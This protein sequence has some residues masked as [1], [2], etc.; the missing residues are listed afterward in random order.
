VTPEVDRI[1]NKALAK[2]PAE[3]YQHADD[4]LPDLRVLQKQ[5]GAR[6]TSVVLPPAGTSVV[7]PADTQ[8]TA[9]EPGQGSR[10]ILER[11]VA[12]IATLAFLGLLALHMSEPSGEAPASLTRRF[13]ISQEGLSSA[14]VSPDGRYV[15]FATGTMPQSSLWLR[16]IGAETA[17]EIPGTEGARPQV[18]WSPDSQSIVFA[19]RAEI[20][21][22]G[23]DGADP[24]TLGAL[25]GTGGDGLRG[26]SWSPDGERIVFSSARR[27]SQIPA[28]G[29]EARLLLD[30]DSGDAV[31]PHFLPMTNGVDVIVYQTNLDAD[32]QIWTLNLET[33]ERSEVGPGSAPVYSPDGYLIHGPSE[34]DE[35][36]LHALPFSLA[37]LQRTGSSFPIAAGGR[38][39]SLA[40]DGTLV[41]WDGSFAPVQ[42]ALVWRDRAGEVIETI[43]RP[44]ARMTSPS[45]S[46]DGQRIAVASLETGDFDIWIHDL[47]RST[48][49]RLTFE[50]GRELSPFWS[51]SG[52]E[53]T[54]S[55]P[56]GNVGS[57]TRKNADGTGEAVVLVESEVSLW[58]PSWSPDGRYLAY[59]A[60]DGEVGFDIRFGELRSDGEM[61]DPVTFLGTP[62]Y[63]GGAR[64]SPDGRFV[65]YRSDES[66]RR[67][68]YVRSF[69][70]GDGKWQ[71]SVNG[72]WQP[73]WRPD[74]KELYYVEGEDT[75]M[76]VSVST[77]PTITLGP[78][79][80]L[81]RSEDLLRG[82]LT[83]YDVT[84]DGERFVTI[85][86]VRAIDEEVPPPR[87]R[88]VQNWYEEFRERQQ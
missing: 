37:S 10:R 73:R 30:R 60:G 82:G 33:G 42:W 43:S 34:L 6:K 63:E 81:F 50:E 67:E 76:S 59:T 80:Q 26:A 58:A 31:Q 9:V 48:K 13:S 69:P 14:S 4:L 51:S 21:R 49:M 20:K 55:R 72:G 40:H 23:L 18:G 46:P 16:A 22:V 68:V 79:Q 56:G 24:V 3:R 74:G 87:I 7:S 35:Q 27:L 71:V 52:R 88:I 17:R 32:A 1:L 45:L 5:S 28:R 29:G 19:T 75:L 44:Q 41:F 84:A 83:E 47:A 15:A 11:A 12:I 53:I 64:I 8:P 70:D 78:P 86:T 57:L 61:S 2:D 39:A 85:S 77:E 54:Y 65:A 62:T 38:I 25:P 66:G 36:G